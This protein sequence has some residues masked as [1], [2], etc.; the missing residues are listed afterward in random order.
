MKYFS[1]S[2]NYSKYIEEL[3]AEKNRK[4]FKEL[5]ES[6]KTKKVETIQ[7]QDSFVSKNDSIDL[8]VEQ[9]TSYKEN[10]VIAGEADVSQKSEDNI[11][12]ENRFEKK[13]SDSINT[14][15]NY[16]SRKSENKIDNEITVSSKEESDFNVE[17]VSGEKSGK[18]TELE[19]SYENK[20][21]NNLN[22]VDEF[23]NKDSV[24]V[25]REE[26]FESKN[27]DKIN[28]ET[29]ET[30]K[31]EKKFDDRN[32]IPEK[33]KINFN[34]ENKASKK[35]DLNFNNENKVPEKNEAGFKYE[36]NIA[37][38]SGL[39]FDDKNK[40]SEKSGA[41]FKYEIQEIKKEKRLLANRNVPDN[42]QG[43]ELPFGFSVPKKVEIINPEINHYMID[44]EP[45][46]KFMNMVYPLTKR[47]EEE[48]YAEYAYKYTYYP[49][50]TYSDERTNQMGAISDIFSVI[51]NPP[52]MDSAGDIFVNT[53][54]VATD[55]VDMLNLTGPSA[56]IY[57]GSTANNLREDLRLTTNKITGKDFSELDWG[58]QKKGNASFRNDYIIT[59]KVDNIEKNDLTNDPKIKEDKEIV[60][61]SD[62]EEETNDFTSGLGSKNI[63]N[64]KKI[65]GKYYDDG[66]EAEDF[67]SGLG[68][69]IIKDGKNIG[70]SSDPE[71]EITAKVDK[72]DITIKNGN[73]TYIRNNYSDSNRWFD[74]TNSI[75]NI[76]VMP[77][78]RELARTESINSKKDVAFK[79][80]LQNSLKFEQTSRSA[81]WTAIQFFGRIGDVQQYSRTG[82]LDAI[83]VTT[84][85]FYDG[86]DFTMAKIQD[87]EM[88][89]RSLVLPAEMSDNYLND[90][91]PEAKE[92][93]NYYYFTRPPVINI[94]LG[95][96]KDDEENGKPIISK[97]SDINIRGVY[98][99]LFT[100]I[101]TKYDIE[102]EQP[103]TH[104]IYYKNFIVTSVSID[105]NQE[106]YNYYIDEKNSDYLDTTGFTVTLTLLE[107]DANYIGSMPSFN[108]YYN[109]LKSRRTITVN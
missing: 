100:D 92:A 52:S 84:K 89:Y 99:N 40:I 33:N 6:T 88:A 77:P 3:K 96:N 19:N 55:V 68:S 14:E 104:E 108:N 69:K 10:S 27:D 11:S 47:R 80:P 31:D 75:G 66:A 87:I 107:I 94:V 24:D 61:N 43:R 36:N 12:L 1:Y 50:G 54:R 90:G 81:A 97:A 44:D 46:F 23:S 17:E 7:I 5:V 51:A 2:N 93:S 62:G 15:S 57:N 103:Y 79:I 34:N 98:K 38:K 45:I 30:V 9:T 41:E 21:E 64:G 76:Y 71:K 22:K 109:T 28:F 56:N 65:V 82:S 53:L 42:K 20:I 48:L 83:T 60:G 4:A 74:E 78:L 58:H 73:F 67:T 70:V 105:K 72:K 8:G 91:S 16:N 32:N 85:Y 35:S 102:E 86:G 59:G 13:E 26:S 39:N 49:A 18:E 37:E 63:K 106:E 95:K 25:R 29:E 101:R